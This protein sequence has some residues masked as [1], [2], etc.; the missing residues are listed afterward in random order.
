MMEST[1]KEAV[2]IHRLLEYRP[3]GNSG[4]VT[5]KTADDP[6]DADFIVVDESSMLDIDL[7]NIF[8]SAVKSGALVLFVGDINQLPS[9][10]AGNV[11]YDMIHSD[12]IPVYRLTTIYRQAKESSIVTNAIAVNEGSDQ[13]IQGDD[14]RIGFSDKPSNIKSIVIELVRRLYNK[15]DPF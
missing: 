12:C 11:L 10:G 14:F 3:F 1:G 9:V 8:L 2:T 5:H 4:E 6:I 15:N 7:A 13:L